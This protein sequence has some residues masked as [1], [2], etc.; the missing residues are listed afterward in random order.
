MF[1]PDS[2]GG[3]TGDFVFDPDSV[4]GT[5]GDFVFD[6]DSVGGTT[7]DFVFDPDSVGGTTG[8][9]VFDPDSVGGTTG[10]VF[11]GI[12]PGATCSY[13]GLSFDI[14]DDHSAA[15]A[16]GRYTGANIRLAM[17]LRVDFSVSGVISGD[18]FG[19]QFGRQDY[20]ASFRTTPGRKI[21]G[22]EQRPYPAIFE[23]REGEIVQGEFNVEPVAGNGALVV[24]FF[25]DGM[26]PGLPART[27][28]T[29]SAEWKTAAMRT[30]AV[31]LEQETGTEPP[32]SYT[33]KGRTMTYRQAF[34]DAGIE[35]V[36]AGETSRIPR[37]SDGW[38]NTQLHALMM[39]WANADLRQTGWR[40]Q[41]LWLGKPTRSGLLG[42]MFDTTAELPRQGTAV[43][44]QE[45]RRLVTDETN[46]KIIQTTVHEIGHGLNL[47]HRFEREVGRVDST[48]FMNYPWRYRGGNRT[49]EFWEKFNFSFDPDELE[50][51]R[52]A[53][54]NSVI[55]GGAAFHSVNYWKTGS[56]GYMPYAPEDPLSIVELEIKPPQ[57]GPILA[58]GQPV[59]L[60]VTLTNRSGRPMELDQRLL[61]PKGNFLQIAVRRITSGAGS[62]PD[63]AHFHP[64]VERCYDISPGSMELVAPG[65]KITDNIQITFGSGGFTFAEP[66]RYEVQVFG[67]VFVNTTDDDPFN[68]REL[69]AASNK[70]TLHIAHPQSRAEEKDVVNVL[71]RNDVGVFFALGGSRALDKA[72]ND[73]AEILER[74][75]PDLAMVTDPIAANIVR[76]NGIDVGRR[77]RRYASGRFRASDGNPQEAA[78]ELARLTDQALQA[79]DENTAKATKALRQRHLDRIP[80]A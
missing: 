57:G 52:H 56:G 28:F 5:T 9:F 8:D 15:F 75:A 45:I 64:I 30:L 47:A 74:Y 21:N 6:P 18:L 67:S 70:L 42:I 22:S 77:Y 58:F 36:D 40:Q 73:L 49:A 13:C 32:P 38:G 78:A 31:E 37:E 69:V 29:L 2:V 72:T 59:F 54:R 16:E 62:Q 79:F 10:D 19:T 35:I 41:V 24:T 20:L 12:T 34:A 80:D 7:G 46:R 71:H 63:A 68:D 1:D 14:D 39:E 66:G 11:A 23:S 55:P 26:L 43:F 60:K 50:F 27:A 4:G 48:S 17:E 61:D 76:C 51:L 3:T 25:V 44:D 33:F 65:E 53:P